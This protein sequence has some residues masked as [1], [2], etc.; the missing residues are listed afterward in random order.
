M[1]SNNL[2]HLNKENNFFG[3]LKAV[4]DEVNNWVKLKIF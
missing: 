2:E 3:N 1:N 4:Q